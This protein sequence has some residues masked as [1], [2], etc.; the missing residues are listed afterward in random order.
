M[1]IFF[2]QRLAFLA[3]PKAGSTAIEAALGSLATAVIQRP[4]AL[5]HTPAAR[6][7]KFLAPYLQEASGAR[8]TVTALM[9]EPLAWLGSWYRFGQRDDGLAPEGHSRDVS[10]DE[11]VRAWCR[12]DPPEFARVGTQSAFLKVGDRLGVDRLFRYED[13]DAFVHFL[14]DTLDC[15]ITLP[16]LN[17]SPS[18]NMDLTPA[19][20]DLFRQ[21]A[22][23]ELELYESIGRS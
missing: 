15:A 12:S 22:A 2:D 9:R 8:F 11:F 1:L 16:R 6:F 10:F 7:E 19:T 5:K 14:E 18:A 4:D 3:T 21:T 20:Q 23:A 13:I 17:V